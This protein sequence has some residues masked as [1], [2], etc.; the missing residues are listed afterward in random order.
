MENRTRKNQLKIYLS[1]EEKELFNSKMEL[2][3][4]KTMSHFIKK[5]VAEKEIYTVDMKPFHDLHFLLSNMANN[6]NQI[7]RKTNQT[8]IIHQ[9]DIQSMKD[10]IANFSKKLLQIHALLLNKTSKLGSE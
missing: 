5:C 6:L 8:G 4:C 3:N 1:D 9:A 7:A 2:A 10:E